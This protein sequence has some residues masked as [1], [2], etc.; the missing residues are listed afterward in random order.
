M[1]KEIDGG[2]LAPQ[3]FKASGIAAGIKKNGA[4]DMAM[5][6]SIVPAATALVTTQNMVKAAPVL[7]DNEIVKANPWTQAIV[8]NSGNAN[9]CTGE[10]GMADVQNTA[11][12]AACGL[13]IDKEM[14]LVSST[15]VIGVPLP[16]EKITKGVDGLIAALTADVCGADQSA[17]AILTTDTVPKTCALEIEIDGKTVRI[18]GMAKGSGMICPN[19]AT[20]L[21]YVTTDAKI[22]PDCLQAM[23]SSITK[24]TYNMMSV[25]GD[26]STNDT[27]AV[28]ANGL[29]G[30][31]ELTLGDFGSEAYVTFYDALYQVNETL[32]KAIVKD[33]EGATKFI[34]TTV[35][36]AKGEGDARILA[37][38]VIQSSLVKTA[39]FGEDANWGRVLS[40]LGASGAIFDPMTVSVWFESKGGRIKLLD[41]GT[42]ILF[43]EAYAKV[44]LEEK[45]LQI[46]VEMGQGDAQATAW[47][48]DLTYDY[49]KINGDYR[50]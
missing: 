43:D 37:K 36:G 27:L 41:H 28:L 29:A 19:M 11:I 45:E 3:G 47:G 35:S 46:Q 42:P 48:C 1:K 18:G 14:V 33:G 6:Y 5:V 49:V 23:V 26:M 10:Q 9:A 30:N 34:E 22:A 40:S 38:A 20:M 39:I 2:V 17:R 32:A 7:W 31:K 24:D 16:I 50:T 15:G 25:D 44:I 13:G 21:A 4:L 12:K 8:A